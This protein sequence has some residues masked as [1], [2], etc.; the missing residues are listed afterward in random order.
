MSTF[1]IQNISAI[2]LQAGDNNNMSISQQSNI[3]Q[4]DILER[5]FKELSQSNNGSVEYQKLLEQSI[6]LSQRKDKVGLSEVL[7]K[8]TKELFFDL[9][10][11]ALIEIIKLFL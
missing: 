9:S 6:Q 10:K 3:V 7:K 4:W 2:N 8:F 5:E 11:T 1:N